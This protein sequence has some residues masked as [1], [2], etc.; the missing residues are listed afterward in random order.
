MPWIYWFGLILIGVVVVGFIFSGSKGTEPPTDAQV[1][2]Q[3]G[4]R[5]ADHEY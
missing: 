5:S 3:W 2:G 1:Y 4:P